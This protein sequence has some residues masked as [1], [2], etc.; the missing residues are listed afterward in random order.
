MCKPNVLCEKK[1]AFSV[2][3]HIDRFLLLR[4]NYTELLS[5]TIYTYDVDS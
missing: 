2:L 3:G 5:K 1:T 4:H